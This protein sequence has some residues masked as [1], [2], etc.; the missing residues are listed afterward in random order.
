MRRIF[1]FLIFVHGLGLIICFFNLV[2]LINIIIELNIINPAPNNVK[3]FG[4]SPHI[5]Y[6]NITAKTKF[7][8]LVGVTSEASAILKDTVNKMFATDP[9]T[10]VKINKNNSNF[11]GITHPNGKVINPTNILNNEKYK[12]IL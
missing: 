11:D 3:N 2:S 9:M 10:P 7:K 8:Y 5:K 1:F 4:I 12:A 6:P